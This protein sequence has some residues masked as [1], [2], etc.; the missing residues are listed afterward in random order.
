M[1]RRALLAVLVMVLPHGLLQGL[2]QGL[3]H[4][5]ALLP[6]SFGGSLWRTLPFLY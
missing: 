5:P 1:L 3:L 4:V 2:L 6:P